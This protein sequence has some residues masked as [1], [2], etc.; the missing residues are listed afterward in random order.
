M[1]KPFYQNHESRSLS[2]KKV[3]ITKKSFSDR[4]LFCSRIRDESPRRAEKKECSCQTTDD[5][6]LAYLPQLR[7]RRKRSGEGSAPEDAQESLPREK[8]DTDIEKVEKEDDEEEERYTGG[9]SESPDDD[10]DD[11]GVPEEPSDISPLLDEVSAWSDSPRD[12]ISPETDR[13]FQP[14]QPKIQSMLERPLL[15][16]VSILQS[17]SAASYDGEKRDKPP[18]SD[19]GSRVQN[20]ADTVNP[21][22]SLLIDI[23]R[24]M[25][26]IIKR[27]QHKPDDLVITE[28]DSE[29]EDPGERCAAAATTIAHDGAGDS[30]DVNDDAQS[31]NPPIHLSSSPRDSIERF[32]RALQESGIAV[33]LEEVQSSDV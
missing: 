12:H 23:P 28:T 9:M 33:D 24:I 6:L 1:L 7:R 25:C 26:S 27:E 3:T 15:M 2:F 8:T 11:V 14:F 4:I 22:D 32:Q 17:L 20:M 5:L 29:N 31:L 13:S 21:T 10:N 18:G 16:P 30:S 19:D